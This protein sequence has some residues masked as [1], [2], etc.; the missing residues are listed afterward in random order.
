MRFALYLRMAFVSTLVL[1]VQ[2][3]SDS[4]KDASNNNNACTPTTCEAEGKNCGSMSD[5]CSDT[6]EC[7]TCSDPETCGG[8]GVSNV[9]A[10]ASADDLIPPGAVWRYLDDGT[11][12]G[13][14][15]RESAFDDTAWASGPAELGYGD[16]GEATVVGY[17]ADSNNK[18][19][20]TYFRS[21]FEVTDVAGLSTLTLK[22]VVDDGAVVFLN[23]TEVA[24]LNMPAGDVTY[25]TLATS[26]ISGSSEAAWTVTTIG[27]GGLVS[28]TNVIA[29]EVHQ[30][31][32]TSTDISFNLE[33][34][35]S[36]TPATCATTNCGTMSDGCGGTLTCPDC[37]GVGETCGGG[38]VDNV[39]GVSSCTPATCA[40]E[41]KEC[42]SYVESVCHTTLDCGPCTSGTCINNACTAC[43]ASTCEADG[44]ECGSYVESGCGTTLTCPVCAT[45]TCVD[46]ACVAC[47]VS[48]CGADGKNCGDYAESGCGTTLNCGTC[49]VSG[50]WCGGSGTANVCGA[51]AATVLVTADSTWSYLDDGSSQDT[52]PA[53]DWRSVGWTD[54]GW[55]T[56]PAELGYGDS[57]ATTITKQVTT[58]FRKTVT[59]ADASLFATLV[60]KLVRDDGAVVYLNGTEIVRSNMPS[61]TA[62]STLASTRMDGDAE[63]AWYESILTSTGLLTTGTNVIAVEVHQASTNSSDCSFNLEL[64]AY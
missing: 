9:C 56:G 50:E 12:Q 17:G 51:G 8:A 47:T 24:R 57:P 13:T 15:W 7:G 16:D 37:T 3:C 20:T 5:G 52:D 29:V 18:Y 55:A 6:L 46:N 2:A 64:L 42:G 58:F 41:S 30:N 59:V 26:N 49:G 63:S 36:C 28:G 32:V 4:S 1:T 27:A 44:K 61:E 33:L 54:P 23:G 34:A 48:T 21:S 25:T 31:S 14:A 53:T 60:V 43:T 39:C 40:A 45:G 11:D 22:S 38:G 10:E 19:V 35:T 62:N